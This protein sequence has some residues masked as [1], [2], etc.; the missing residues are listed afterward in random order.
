[1]HVLEGEYALLY[2]FLR[3]IR[4]TV[5]KVLELF[6]NTGNKITRVTI[7]LQNIIFLRRLPVTEILCYPWHAVIS[8]N[9][10]YFHTRSNFVPC[11]LR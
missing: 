11:I 6:Y 7:M 8:Q 3:G 2:L 5:S 9:N 4:I 1:V 10:K